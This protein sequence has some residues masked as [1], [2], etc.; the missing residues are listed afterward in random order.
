[1]T[2]VALKVLFLDYSVIYSSTRIGDND[3]VLRR[4][5]DLERSGGDRNLL[6][7]TEVLLFGAGTFSCWGGLCG[8]CGGAPSPLHLQ[9]PTR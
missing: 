3:P 2:S 8:L 4:G 6:A 7:L 1:M 9:S 5:L